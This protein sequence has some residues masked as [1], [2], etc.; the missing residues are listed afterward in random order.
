MS[1]STTAS[2]VKAGDN[3]HRVEPI[4]P[5]SAVFQDAIDAEVLAVFPTPD[6][7][8]TH[9]TIELVPEAPAHRS[10]LNLVNDRRVFL[11]A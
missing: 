8:D 11:N 2:A 1:N 6:F 7:E 3:L 5:R 10:V 9:T 4:S